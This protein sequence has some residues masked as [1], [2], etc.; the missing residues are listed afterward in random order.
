MKGV[1]PAD[2]VDA[3]PA[4]VQL[5]HAVKLRVPLLDA[6]RHLLVLRPR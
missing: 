1:Y 2:E 3:L 4:T 5:V 6:E